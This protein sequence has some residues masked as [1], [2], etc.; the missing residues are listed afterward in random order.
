MNASE[1]SMRCRNQ[2]RQ[3]SSKPVLR[4]LTWDECGGNLFTAR[5]V[6]GI[7]MA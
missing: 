4:E 1:P 7:E 6:T 2:R 5:M 3:T